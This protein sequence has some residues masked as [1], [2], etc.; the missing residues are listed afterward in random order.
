VI[1][2][3]ADLAELYDGSVPLPQEAL[4]E[5]AGTSR[6]T[7]NRVLRDLERRH[8][9]VL[10]RARIEVEELERLRPKPI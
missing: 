8:V 10:G 7:V 5:L 2:R 6:A 3:L 9:V 4:A 1:K